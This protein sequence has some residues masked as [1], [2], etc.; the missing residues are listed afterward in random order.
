MLQALRTALQAGREQAIIVGT[1]SPALPLGH[2]ESLLRSG[3]DVALGPAD[4]GGYYAIACRRVCERM[5]DGVRWSAADTMQRTTA[6][7]RACGL[8][9]EHGE[10]YWDVD[11]P[12]DLQRLLAAHDLPRHTAQIVKI[13]KENKANAQR[14]RSRSQY[15]TEGRER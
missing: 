7:V 3:A 9:V 12:E 15:Q 2:I 10:P 8:T 14:R 4:D 6:A 1:D 5:F 11:T 13:I